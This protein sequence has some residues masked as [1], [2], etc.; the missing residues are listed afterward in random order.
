MTSGIWVLCMTAASIGVVHTLLGPDHYLPFL[1]LSK[2]RGWSTRR[3]VII[4]MLCGLG[5]VI[6]SIV[7][8]L[9]G[10][11][12]G[13]ALSRLEYFEAL[14]GSLAA[15]LLIGIGFAYFVWGVHRAIRNRPHQHEH[16]HVEGTAHD[17]THVHRSSHTHI[18]TQKNGDLTAWALF[19][20]FI[21]GPCEPLI[22]ILM[23]PAARSSTMGMLL[24]AG[25]FAVATITTM[26][27][28]V[29][30]ANWGASFVKIGRAERYAHAVA[31]AVICCSGLTIQ[32]LGL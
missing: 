7:L 9:I 26:V 17:H 10:V 27:G 22:P 5:H 18:H 20:F 29:L 4:T 31:G 25:V 3:T 14:R 32:F 28:A 1:A 8:G 23:F 12:A 15:W 13:V 2:A 11:A 30:L 16:V 21:L 24:V 6:G 19:L